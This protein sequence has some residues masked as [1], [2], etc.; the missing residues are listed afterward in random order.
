MKFIQTKVIDELFLIFFINYFIIICFF[1]LDFFY[2]IYD[3]FI[4]IDIYINTPSLNNTN[5]D[6]DS[7][8][9]SKFNA[10][11]SKYYMDPLFHPLFNPISKDLSLY[12]KYDLDSFYLF[13]IYNILYQISFDQSQNVECQISLLKK[14]LQLNENFIINNQLE[15]ESELELESYLNQHFKKLDNLIYN[16]TNISSHDTNFANIYNNKMISINNSLNSIFNILTEKD[17]EN[18]IKSYSVTGNK[19]N[20]NILTEKDIENLIK[21]NS[22][23]GNKINHNI[24]ITNL[25]DYVNLDL[26]DFLFNFK[27][28]KELDESCYRIYKINILL[29][30]FFATPKKKNNNKKNIPIMK[31][32][33]ILKKKYIKIIKKEIITKIKN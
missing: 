33:K 28:L 16:L 12:S 27:E 9:N 3:L 29:F 14:V 6:I 2:I 15:I 25:E 5:Y 4:N 21:N 20:Y 8:F 31:V 24:L 32:L 23:T 22:I 26:T 1:N 11:Y 19:I 7:L 13:N 30:F 10:L 18:L 17:I